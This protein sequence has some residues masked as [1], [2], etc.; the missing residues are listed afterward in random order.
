[1]FV[2][3]ARKAPTGSFEHAHLFP[4]RGL[5]RYDFDRGTSDELREDRKGLKKPGED[6]RYVSYVRV[7]TTKQGHDGNGVEAQRATVARYVQ[8]SGGVLL[9]E[10]LEVESGAH[11]TLTRRPQLRAA[12]RHAK[13]E[14]AT[15]LIAKLDRL[16][17]SVL[18]TAQLLTSGVEFIACDVPHANRLTLH[19]MAAIAEY[20]SSIIS[21]RTREAMAAAK[22]RGSRFGASPETLRRATAASLRARRV[23]ASTSEPR[24][25]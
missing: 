2:C 14:R 20:E 18:L 10:Y 19:I 24:S 25:A 5:R 13:H 22:A 7:S 12:L 23:R 3:P 17:R 6:Q 15:L 8:A 9:T 16:S 11:H 1:V 21:D 4:P